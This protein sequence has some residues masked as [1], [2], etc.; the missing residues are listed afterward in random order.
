VQ[1]HP[2]TFVFLL[3]AAILVGVARAMWRRPAPGAQTSAALMAA[4]AV[5]SAA[6][7]LELASTSQAAQLAW[8]PLV[9][10]GVLFAPVA[11][12]VFALR[13]TG[14]D[15]WLNTGAL[16]A[17][18]I[19]PV[20]LYLL[21]VTDPW[22]HLVYQQVD[23][24]TDGRWQV[25]QLTY[26]PAGWAN[27]V[28]AYTCLAAGAAVI[29]GAFWASPRIYRRQTMA[30]LLS[31]LAPWLVNALYQTGVGPIVDLT[32]L[33]FTLTGLGTAWAIRRA[34]LLDLAPV[35]RGLVVDSLGDGVAV[36]DR[37]GRLTDA[38]AALRKIV[39]PVEMGTLSSDLFRPFPALMAQLEGGPDAGPIAAVGEPDRYYEP[40]VTPLVNRRGGEVGR[41]VTFRDVTDRRRVMAELSRARDAAEDLARA[42]SQ[43]LA[44]VSHEIR[45]PMNGVIGMT[46]LLL[47][48]KLDE[49][50][51]MFVETIRSSGGQ[52]LS[53]INDILDFSKF[54]AGQLV[55]EHLPFDPRAAVGSVVSLLNPEAAAKGLTLDFTAGTDVPA[56]CAGDEFRVRQIVTNLV[57][58]A[59][60]FTE[61]GRVSVRLDAE[62]MRAGADVQRMRLTVSDTGIGIPEDRVDRLFRPFS[63]V[64]ASVARRFG[65][66]GLGLAISKGLAEM[67]GGTI[68]VESAVGR[69]ST[70]TAEW[71]VQPVPDAQ[72]ATAHTVATSDPASGAAPRSVKILVAEDNPVNQLVVTQMLRRLGYTADVVNDGEAAVAAVATVA[73]DLVLMDVQMPNMDGLSAT[74]VI[75]TAASAQPRIIAMTANAMPGDREVC[76]SAGMDDYLPKPLNLDALGAAIVRNTSAVEM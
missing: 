38:N 25:L 39:G 47:D 43:F 60:K 72:E 3:S 35:A 73:Y 15:G 14:R 30:L 32:P 40:S 46:G 23:T 33:G 44:T 69:G 24:I 76:L 11:W 42:K 67:M 56:R 45:T 71:D 20:G 2:F 61:T 18:A 5:W 49:Q 31:A 28:Y 36:L 29:L 19:V 58:N 66:T 54:D 12:F 8:A 27:V 59:V 21:V 50:Q 53:I 6:Y 63:Q 13:F 51:R 64:D 41:V 57:G 55:I 26:G 74:R 17:L 48:T 37:Q 10:I 62:P 52:L 9:Y 7:A 65:G 68:T 1:A 75:R 4:I 16:V 34:Q 70:F 22:H